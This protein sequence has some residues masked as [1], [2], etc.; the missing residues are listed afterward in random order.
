MAKVKFKANQEYE[1][2]QNFKVLQATFT[3]NKVDKN[4]PVDRLIKC[5]FQDNLEFLQWVKKFWD[6]HYSGRL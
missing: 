5:R 1:Y 4:I 2:V 3:A 6:T